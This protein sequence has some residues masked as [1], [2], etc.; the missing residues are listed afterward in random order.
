MTDDRDARIQGENRID[1]QDQGAD[2][3]A[4]PVKAA[5]GPRLRWR[6]V[7]IAVASLIGVACALIYQLAALVTSVPWS[8][9]NGLLPGLAGLLNGLWLFAGPLAIVIV[10]KPGAALYGE[11][12]AAILESL[13]GNQWVP[14]KTLGIG[15]VQGALA[16]VVFLALRYRKWNLATT[17]LS[18]AASALGCWAFSFFT[19]LQ[20]INLVGP[21]GI[22][23]LVT[24]VLSGVLFAGVMVWYLYRAIARTGALER[25]ESGRDINR[26]RG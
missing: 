7:D 1:R 16:E 21:Y 22:T 6:V 4:V 12:V 17:C 20:A 11:L 19:H 13:M 15:L 18:G 10:R 8:V 3:K 26:R 9:I 2:G 5:S 14:A 25:F 24:T 23:Y